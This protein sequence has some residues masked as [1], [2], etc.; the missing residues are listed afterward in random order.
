MYAQLAGRLAN[1]IVSSSDFV[2]LAAECLA[3][4]L[5]IDCNYVKLFLPCCVEKSVCRLFVF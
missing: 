2:K 1:T 4:I 5:L 3:W